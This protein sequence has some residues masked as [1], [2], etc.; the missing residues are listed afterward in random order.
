MQLGWCSS[1]WKRCS[2]SRKC[3]L[4]SRPYTLKMPFEQ[5]TC[6]LFRL[7]PQDK[8]FYR[9]YYLVTFEKMLICSQNNSENPSELL[10]HLHRQVSGVSFC[11]YLL[12][13]WNGNAVFLYLNGQCLFSYCNVS[14]S[15]LE[16]GSTQELELELGCVHAKAKGFLCTRSKT[17][18]AWTGG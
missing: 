10:L 7:L 14:D 18:L 16:T 8:V 1:S 15:C 4:T 13:S 12:L 3:T 5:L 6:R 2:D 17:S 11:Y 9:E